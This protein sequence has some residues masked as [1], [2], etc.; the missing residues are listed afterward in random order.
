VTTDSAVPH[1]G[2]GTSLYSYLY[3]SLAAVVRRFSPALAVFA[4]A[5]IL[6][7]AVASAQVQVDGPHDLLPQ[8]IYGS[9]NTGDLRAGQNPWDHKPEYE[10]AG[11][12]S[13][14]ILA[15]PGQ[16]WTLRWRRG[17]EDQCP[18]NDP[19]CNVLDLSWFHV[20]VEQNHEG[21]GNATIDYSYDLLPRAMPR[22]VVF[23]VLVPGNTQPV[24]EFQFVQE[25]DTTD[26]SVT[27]NPINVDGYGG[28]KTI[29]IANI[30]PVAGWTATTGNPWIQIVGGTGV[31]P[32]NFQINILPNFT[33]VNRTGSVSVVGK[34]VIVNQGFATATFEL[35]NGS[36]HYPYQ[37]GTG[38]IVVT[39]DDPNAPWT[40]VS[41][42]SWITITN[43]GNYTGSGT[44]TYTV[45]LNP[46]QEPRTGTISVAGFT[47]TVTQDPNP[48]EPPPSLTVSP[49]VLN[50]V[51]TPD[52]GSTLTQTA[53]VGSTGDPLNFTVQ[54][55]AAWLTANISGGTTPSTITFTANPAGLPVGNY[56]GTV[57]VSEVGGS[58]SQVTIQ[59]NLQV[60]P[61][62]DRAP[63]LNAVP[64]SLYFKRE[65][66]GPLP[67]PQR[68]RLANPGGAVNYLL[69]LESSIWL[70]VQSVNDEQG[71]GVLVSIR[72]LNI[73]PGVYDAKVTVRSPTGAFADLEVPIRYVVTMASV[74]G[75]NISSGGIVN[76]ATFL[77]GG[78]PGAWISVFGQNLAN[79]TRNWNP[80]TQPGSL[81]PTVM[82]GVEVFIAGQPAPISFISPSQVN[83]LVPAVPERGWVPVEVRVNG[84]PTQG[85]YI[86][87]R[88]TDPA[89]FTYSPQGGRYPAAQHPNGATLGPVGLFPGGPQ[90]T[91]ARP[92]QIIVLYGTGF[93]ATNPPVNPSTFFMGSAPLAVDH[94]DIR[95]QV[96]GLNGQVQY[97]GLI[98]P[99]LYQINL[100]L[101]ALVD[102]EYFINADIDGMTTQP[103]LRI[104]IKE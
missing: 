78:A 38:N 99:G 104:A 52:R 29:E 51:Y 74:G 40:A 23:E 65:S 44:V 72:N 83:A 48:G 95:V 36:A 8:G 62:T 88:D 93:G 31:G 87:L 13:F 10:A 61:R 9:H 58:N 54:V 50:F 101:P 35:G 56:S 76:A 19:G 73:I 3:R 98:A 90:S 25:P 100:V 59:V 47:F 22:T 27:P 39:V 26:P 55:N 11:S 20:S 67:A 5:S 80:S 33:G 14:Q 46:D 30:S 85:G 84:Q 75:P 18:A 37:G 70:N 71:P 82:D 4:F 63:S 66:G 97:I 69:D 12:A 92:T 91:P 2:P 57:V 96:G 79:T 41:N 89:L 6:L 94:N 28:L 7:P 43:G 34:T 24:A 32:G 86:Y 45:A 64:R 60:R 103:G 16:Q 15:N 42:D 21:N 102:G 68:I 81:L 77:A 17:Y 53:N 1:L 49:T